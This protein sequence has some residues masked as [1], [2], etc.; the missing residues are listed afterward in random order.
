MNILFVGGPPRSGTTALVRYL[1]RHPRVLLCMERYKWVPPHLIRPDLFTFERILDY[2]TG[3]RGDRGETNTPREHHVELLAG[4]DPERL[5][6]IGDKTPAYVEKMRWLSENNPGASFIIT[7][8]PLEEVAESFEARS[9]DPGSP[10]RLGGFEAGV[11]HWNAAMRSTRNFLN[12]AR[13]LNVLVVSYHDFFYDNE[14]LIP[15]LSSFLDIEIGHEMRDA[16]REMSRSFEADRRPK[17]SLSD[18]M[19][20]YLEA[21]KE[22][23]AEQQVLNRIRRQRE[24]LDLY[25]PD[26]LRVLVRERRASAVRIAKESKRCRLLEEEAKGLK[27]RI[28]DLQ[29][30]LQDVSPQ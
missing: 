25:G 15:L 5:E 26:G 22:G 9:N 8:R 24:E 16:W 1:N 4:K 28:R 7:Y 27:D 18:E 30:Q 3:P 11:E 21:N 23:T 10:W 6:W 19:R 29:Q 12:S 20:T 14:A 2:R 17:K 13:N